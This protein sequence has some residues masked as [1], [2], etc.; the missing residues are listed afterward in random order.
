MAYRLILD[1][2]LPDGVRRIATQQFGRIDAAFASAGDAAAAVHVSRK[3]LKKLRA[4]FALIR[5]ALDAAAY[6]QVNTGL[7]DIGRAL[8][9][10]RDAAVAGLAL[11]GLA[12]NC[13]AG[14]AAMFKRVRT[15]L[16]KSLVGPSTGDAVHAPVRSDLARA[17]DLVADLDLTRLEPQHLF[18]GAGQ[19]YAHGRRGLRSIGPAGA[20]PD[21]CAI[22]LHNWRKSVQRHGRHM[23]LL[24]PIW[25]AAIGARIDDAWVVSQRLGA[26]NDLAVLH[27]LIAR[28][29]NRIKLADQQ[30]VLGLISQRQTDLAHAP[31]WL[32]ERLY[33]QSRRRF[34]RDLADFWAVAL[35]LN[36]SAR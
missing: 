13:D 9:A 8:A 4:L 2:P 18:A 11:E 33:A 36:N 29:D 17:A 24:S 32:G 26:Y 19:T 35:K 31:V 27:A 28:Q 14:S 20:G 34:E 25:P 12:A 22:A 3:S 5:P 7:R 23:Q 16:R 10:S 15:G 6:V 30:A 1:E 21:A